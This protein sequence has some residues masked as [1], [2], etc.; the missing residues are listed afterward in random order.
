MNVLHIVTQLELGGAQRSTLELLTH[1]DR[2]RF[3]PSLLSSDGWL[4]QRARQIPRL[5]VT[6]WPSLRR[7]IHPLADGWT[8][9]KLIG[10]IRR[11]GYD[12]VHT[13]SS[14]AGILGRWAAHL[15]KTPAVVHTVHGF[16]FHA[17]QPPWMRRF[18]Q[19]LER[20]TSRITDGFIMV[21]KRDQDTALRLGIGQPGRH[22]LI[23]YGVESE[24]FHRND[25]PQAVH[26]Q[27]LGL[28]PDQPVVGTVA[29]LKAQ[30]APLD[31]VQACAMIK[32]QV[33]A[34]Q[35]LLIGDGALRP[36]VEQLRRRVGLESSLHLLG[37]RDDVP[38]LLAAMD[39]FM[40]ASRWEGLPIACL[41]AMASGLPV[42]AT[43]AGGIPEIITHGETGCVVPI[44]QPEQL[45][46][47]A[48]RL[49]Q[50]RTLCHRMGQAGRASLNGQGTLHHMVSQTEQFYEEL[51][52]SS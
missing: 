39:L 40:L 21:S 42:V 23:R 24:R 20:R 15:A 7:T 25:T 47:A 8:L 51:L 29:C 17:F 13:H 35:F 6:L 26:R 19:G 27:A 2:R 46:R 3:T 48:V 18:Y 11:G 5:S 1:L 44:A 33:S 43:T 14:K 45:A 4:A 16:G 50:D 32:R 38:E 49:L 36:Q 52:G 37:W 10:F 30:K 41:E 31:F 28:D 22:R 12:L 34:A 9:T